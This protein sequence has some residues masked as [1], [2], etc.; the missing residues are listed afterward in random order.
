MDKF[1]KV[2]NA[3]ELIRDMKNQALLNKDNNALHS[4]K[5][6]KVRSKEMCNTINDINTMKEE[7][8]DIKSMMQQILQKL[9]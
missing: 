6:A 1:A 3:P 5:K 8:N 7:M 4:Y 2:E 9:G